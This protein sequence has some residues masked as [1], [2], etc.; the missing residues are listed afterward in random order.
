MLKVRV[1]SSNSSRKLSIDE[2]CGTA[3]FDRA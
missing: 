1:T 3:L 2:R